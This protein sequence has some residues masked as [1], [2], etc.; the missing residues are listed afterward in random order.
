MKFESTKDY[1]KWL[2]EQL[3]AKATPAKKTPV[4]PTKVTKD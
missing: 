2:A 4:K 3:K 1:Q